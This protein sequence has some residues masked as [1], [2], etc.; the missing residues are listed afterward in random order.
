MVKGRPWNATWRTAN[1]DIPQRRFTTC[2]QEVARHLVWIRWIQTKSSY[3]SPSRSLWY[4]YGRCLSHLSRRANSCTSPTAIARPRHL[5]FSIA[6]AVHSRTASYFVKDL[7]GHGSNLQAK[8]EQFKPAWQSTGTGE[9][10]IERKSLTANQQA[11]AYINRPE[12]STL[13][14]S[15]VKGRPEPNLFFVN[16]HNFASFRYPI[17]VSQL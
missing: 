2:S 12:Y 7:K 9:R 5:S 10:W 6:V 8:I 15:T 3:S 11:T 16:T 4:Y 1:K 17:T 14:A 13:E